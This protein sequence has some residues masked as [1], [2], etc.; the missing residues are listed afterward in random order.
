MNMF[1]VSLN[2]KLLNWVHWLVEV[3]LQIKN[4]TS[5][6]LTKVKVEIQNICGDQEICIFLLK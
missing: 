6:T 1:V 4:T 3:V 5:L 2:I